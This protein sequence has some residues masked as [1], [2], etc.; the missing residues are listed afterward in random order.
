[1][2]RSLL[3]ALLLVLAGC[4]AES[5]DEAPADADKPTIPFQ[6]DG[7]VTFY[8]DG[9]EEVTIDVE[10]AETDSARERGLMERRSLPDQSGMLFL[11]PSTERSGFWMANTPLSLDI[12]FV[13]PD[14]QIV[15]IAKYTTPYSSKNVP[16]RQPYRFVV[17]V[18]AGFSDTHGIVEGDRIRWRREEE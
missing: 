10:I 14:S 9:D 6:K 13:G 2:T 3:L 8:Q 18:P 1:M 4:T 17:E 7:E 12:I 15:D 11:F 16:S 5:S